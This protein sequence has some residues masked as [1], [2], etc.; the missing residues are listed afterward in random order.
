MAA[1]LGARVSEA[2]ALDRLRRRG[3]GGASRSGLEHVDEDM[4]IV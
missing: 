1:L 3:G 4:V 2:V